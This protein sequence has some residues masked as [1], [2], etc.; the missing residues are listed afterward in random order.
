MA[1]TYLNNSYYIDGNNFKYYYYLSQVLNAKGEFEKAK[2][3]LAKCSILEADYIESV[4]AG[5]G[6]YGK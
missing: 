5:L 3:S 1:E 4:N 6:V 2:Q